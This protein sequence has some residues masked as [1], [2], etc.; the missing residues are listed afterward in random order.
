[1][2]EG[3]VWSLDSRE[4]NCLS[5]ARAGLEFLGKHLVNLWRAGRETDDQPPVTQVCSERLGASRSG[6]EAIRASRL[7]RVVKKKPVGSQI[8]V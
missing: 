6:A 4:T 2:G 8:R 1:M 3:V 5:Q 7:P